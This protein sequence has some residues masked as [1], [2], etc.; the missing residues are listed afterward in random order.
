MSPV[1]VL[2]FVRVNL[3]LTVQEQE[4]PPAEP[5]D[6]PRHGDVLD[7]GAMAPRPFGSSTIFS[8]LP[9]RHGDLRILAVH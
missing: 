4:A 6:T 8:V 1:S 5:R 2:H 7:G 3:F 9:M